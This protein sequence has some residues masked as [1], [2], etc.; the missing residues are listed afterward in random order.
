MDRVDNKATYQC[1]EGAIVERTEI[2]SRQAAEVASLAH[3]AIVPQDN[4][5]S[6]H[7]QVDDLK[8]LVSRL[9]NWF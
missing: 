6:G 1:L 9:L 5:K 7:H 4:V 3:H 8:A 2:A